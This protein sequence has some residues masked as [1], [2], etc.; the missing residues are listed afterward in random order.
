MGIVHPVLVAG[1]WR[2]SR[3]HGGTLRAFNPQT[4]EARP[5]EYPVSSFEE[6]H[7]VVQAGVEAA[8]ALDEC[9]IGRRV[10]FSGGKPD[11]YR[12]GDENHRLRR[13]TSPARGERGRVSPGSVRVPTGGLRADDAHREGD[14]RG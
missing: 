3:E 6:L 2:P 12:A 5:D 13:G 9:P 11:R 4:G 7:E 14:R 1:D 8:E 10:Q